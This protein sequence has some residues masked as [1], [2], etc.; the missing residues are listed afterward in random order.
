MLYFGDHLK[1]RVVLH[2]GKYGMCTARVHLHSNI[3]SISRILQ[4]ASGPIKLD[5]NV[6]CFSERSVVFS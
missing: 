2:S 4:Y 1:I 3:H 5:C 6:T